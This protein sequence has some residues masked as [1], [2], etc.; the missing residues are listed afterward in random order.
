M[1]L[2]EVCYARTLHL[3]DIID[4]RHGGLTV[5]VIILLIQTMEGAKIYDDDICKYAYDNL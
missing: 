5:L 1:G 3:V 4:F 2:I